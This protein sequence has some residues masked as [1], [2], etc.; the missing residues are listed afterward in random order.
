MRPIMEVAEELGLDREAVI[1]YGPYKAKIHLDAVRVGG[2]RGK[3]VVVTG[4]TPTPA[5]R[6][7]PPARGKLRPR[8]DSPR[9]SEGWARR[10]SLRYVSLRWGQSSG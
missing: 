10:S 4:I 5:L 1:P 2:A 8:S 9:G 3:M 7:R 6:R